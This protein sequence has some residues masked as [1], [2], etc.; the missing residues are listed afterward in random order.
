MKW[1]PEEKEIY[2]FIHIDTEIESCF[3]VYGNSYLDEIRL[4]I[5]N[6]FKTKIEAETKLKQIKKIL[7]GE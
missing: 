7:N 3:N 4:K 5:G 6:C 1:K 2:Y